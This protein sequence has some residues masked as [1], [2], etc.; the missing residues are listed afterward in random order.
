MC[1]DLHIHTTASDGNIDPVTVVKMAFDAGLT[2]IALA[3]HE[4]TSGYYPAYLTGKK[5]GVKV[6]PAVELLTL[7]QGIEVH[8]LGYFNNPDNRYLQQG[9][10]ELRSRRTQCA[11]ETVYKLGEFGFK[12]S[13][14]DVRK[15]ARPD[16]SVS[17]GHII[18]ALNYAGYIN[19]KEDAIQ[20]LTK[21]L[22]RDGLAYVNY[23]YPFEE[24]VNFIRDSE[25]IVILAHPG[26]IRND[27]I[28]EEICQK[29][30]DGLEVFYYYFGKHRDEYIRRYYKKAQEKSL[31]KTGGSDYH[32]TLTPVVLGENP[33]PCEEVGEFLSL[34]G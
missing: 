9:L 15:V 31:L 23:A 19:E 18:Q 17:N 21:Y 20:I 24:A 14:D 10:A 1:I 11:R 27:R 29:S 32:G 22:K 26:L 34:F 7:Y 33:V 30:I 25:G 5:Y 4:S 16:S 13:W 2:T 8:I 3:D 12:I 28:V 6:I